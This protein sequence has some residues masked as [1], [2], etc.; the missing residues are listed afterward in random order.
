VDCQI[1][2]VGEYERNEEVRRSP[3]QSWDPKLGREK[4]E[5]IGELDCVT[6][7]SNRVDRGNIEHISPRHDDLG[8][9]VGFD[10]EESGVD[11]SQRGA[12]FSCP[13]EYLGEAGKGVEIVNAGVETGGGVFN[14]VGD[15]IR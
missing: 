4:G 1:V 14:F 9:V 13:V 2:E 12:K 7:Q 3:E 5:K 15:D 8:Q 11:C 10:E 6:I